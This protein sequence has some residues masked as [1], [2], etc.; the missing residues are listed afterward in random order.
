VTWAARPSARADAE[1]DIAASSVSQAFTVAFGAAGAAP[2]ATADDRQQGGVLSENTYWRYR[3]DTDMRALNQVAAT[4]VSCRCDRTAARTAPSSR[5]PARRWRPWCGLSLRERNGKDRVLPTL[6]GD[7]YFWLLPGESKT[8]S[9]T[10]RK[11]VSDPKLA[12]RGLQRA[13]YIVIGADW[14]RPLGTDPN[15]LYGGSRCCPRV[16]TA[17]RVN[18]TLRCAQPDVAVGPAWFSVCSGGNDSMQRAV[19]LLEQWVVTGRT[20]ST[21]EAVARIG[22][23]VV[24]ALAMTPP[25]NAC[26]RRPPT[27]P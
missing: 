13:D 18:L 14:G 12:G 26:W 7:N 19:D 9:V 15:P 20:G 3:A 21:S 22:K 23:L 16:G 25:Y 11:S 4:S 5:T 24:T 17:T 6:Y 1:V 2:A 10:P 27:A 8:V